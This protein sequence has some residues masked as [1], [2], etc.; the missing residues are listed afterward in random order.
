MDGCPFAEIS[1]QQVLL[2]GK[3]VVGVPRK[4]SGAFQRALRVVNVL[5][6][7]VFIGKSP[8]AL[9]PALSSKGAQHLKE[10]VFTLTAHG[11]IDVGR[12][13][14]RLCVVGWEVSSP[15]SRDVGKALSEFR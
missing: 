11:K 15:D 10:R 1:G 2:N 7:Y 6:C 5:A 13:Q 8:D 12:I 3:T 9:Q 14:R 4:H